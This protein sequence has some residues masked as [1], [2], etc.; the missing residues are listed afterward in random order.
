MTDEW[1]VESI[2]DEGEVVVVFPDGQR[3][4]V[5]VPWESVPRFRRLVASARER[6]NALAK[7]S[8]THRRR[9]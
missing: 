3:C 8:S 2:S 1:R 9:E 6:E 5:A 4:T 7:S